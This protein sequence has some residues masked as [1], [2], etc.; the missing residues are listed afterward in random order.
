MINTKTLK[1]STE[2]RRGTIKVSDVLRISKRLEHFEPISEQEK[3]ELREEILSLKQQLQN[4]NI[5]EEMRN[6]DKTEL[7]QE[8]KDKLYNEYVYNSAIS[9]ILSLIKY[10][11]CDIKYLIEEYEKAFEVIN[12]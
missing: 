12:D 9:G 4:L 6:K 8:E 3:E 10:G 5:T 7:T 1:L 2:K 11:S